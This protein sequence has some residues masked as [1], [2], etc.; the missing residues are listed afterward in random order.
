MSTHQS[1]SSGDKPPVSKEAG[2]AGQAGATPVYTGLTAVP[3]PPRS[4]P[5]GDLVDEVA[6]RLRTGEL[7]PIQAVEILIDDALQRQLGPFS[8]V[9]TALASELKLLLLEQ[10]KS[11]P[12]LS[13]KMKR[14]GNRP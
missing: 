12:Y 1:D 9:H 10:A 7:T 11:D 4:S 2:E 3:E 13:S 14:L 5:G 6:E 8:E